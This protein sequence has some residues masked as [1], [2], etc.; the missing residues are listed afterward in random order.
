MLWKQGKDADLVSALENE[1]VLGN[2]Q[3]EEFDPG[4]WLPSETTSEE[5]LH[6]WCTERPTKDRAEKISISQ[7]PKWAGGKKNCIVF[8]SNEQGL[9][10]LSTTEKYFSN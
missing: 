5:K 4:L 2:R 3:H 7:S 8:I 9:K 10:A 1:T 6:F